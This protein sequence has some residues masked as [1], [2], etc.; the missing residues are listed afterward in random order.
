LTGASH[1]DPTAPKAH[2]DLVVIGSGPAGI[3]AAVQAAKLKRSVCIVDRC[4]PG[5]GGALVHTGTIP[6][7]AM[8][9]A[10]DAIQGVRKHIDERWVARMMQDLPIERL[11]SRARHVATLEERLLQGHLRSNAIEL[12]QGDAFIEGPHSVRINRAGHTS[13]VLEAGVIL[14]ATGSRPRRPADVPFD[15]WRVVDSDEILRLS[16]VPERMLISGAGI[17]GCEYACIF[18]TM[19]V[20]VSVLDSGK[21]FLRQMDRDV[22]QELKRIMEESGITFFLDEAMERIETKGPLVQ[23]HTA[24]RCIETDLMF[25]AGGRVSNSDHLGIENLGI[26]TSPRGAILVNDHFQTDVPTIYAAGDVIGAPALAATSSHQGRAVSCHAFGGQSQAFPSLYPVGVY[27]IPE[28]SG[29]GKTEAELKEHGVPYVVGHAHYNEIAR[30]HIRGESHGLIKMLV[31]PESYKILGIHIV[32]ADA[33]NLIHIGQAFMI[34][35]RCAQDFVSMI[36]NYPTLAE[37]YR[38]AA[39]NALNKIFSSGIIGSAPQNKTPSAA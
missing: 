6:S 14:I 24:K 7:K 3:H 36:F 20:K 18:A 16:S 21:D 19:V 15:G 9:E 38:I 35:D 22:V 31:C 4:A 33:A 39:F 32:G 23:V 26:K 25:F 8:R 37:G 17:I 13:R 30:G 2:Y 10:L 11:L 27:T 12:V 1:T 29:I 34:S 5:V 28:L